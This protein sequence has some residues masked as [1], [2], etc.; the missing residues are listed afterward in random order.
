MSADIYNTK[1]F[2]SGWW[3]TAHNK[4][5]EPLIGCNLQTNPDNAKYATDCA[6]L[7]HMLA[8]KMTLEAVRRLRPKTDQDFCTLLSDL[9]KQAP[10][11]QPVQ[12]RECGTW[13]LPHADCP[14]DRDPEDE[15][16]SQP[17]ISAD[18]L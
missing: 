12:C 3:G 7:A 16:L 9:S 18:D 8:V 2:G 14:V 5:G 10:V 13:H 1:Q 4:D 17:G 15:R 6:N 11:P